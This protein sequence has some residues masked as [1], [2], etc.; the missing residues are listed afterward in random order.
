MSKSLEKIREQLDRL[1]EKR[2]VYKELLDFYERIVEEQ[3]DSKSTLSVAP[4][5]IREDVRK[6]QIKEGFPLVDKADFSLDYHSSVMLFESLCQIGKNATD[7]MRENIQTIERAMRDGALNLEELL[8]RHFDEGYVN[9]IIEDLK[10]DER[11]L[12]FIIHMSIQPSIDAN[13]T[14]LKDRVDLESWLKGYCPICG[15]L[16]RM[17]ELK[18]EGQRYFLC[19][20]CGFTWPGERLRCPFCENRDHES[21]HYFYAEGQE[22]YRVD[23]CDKCQQYIKTIDTRKLDYEPDLNLEDITTIHLD[24]LASEKGFKRPVPNPWGP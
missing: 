11:I 20:F 4:V 8:R 10:I 18:G 2:P 16:P 13:V 19:S 6:L 24:I 7:T 5:E 21:L 15:L 3:E 22:V 1:R 12:K 23:A 9:E 17:S 14:R